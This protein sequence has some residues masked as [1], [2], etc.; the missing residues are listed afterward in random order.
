MKKTRI[1][2]SILLLVVIATPSLALAQA[3]PAADIND[4]IRKEGMDNSQIMKTLH[5]LTDPPAIFH[6]PNA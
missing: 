4:R 3:A 6:P 5:T 1:T 2:L